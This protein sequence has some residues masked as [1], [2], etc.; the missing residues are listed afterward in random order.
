M[1]LGGLD[2][3]DVLLLSPSWRASE[4]L[5]DLVVELE[6]TIVVFDMMERG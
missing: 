6:N 2:S 3:A 4:D 5:V 1:L